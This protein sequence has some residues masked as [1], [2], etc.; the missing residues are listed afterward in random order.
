MSIALPA[1]DV[2]DDGPLAHGSRGSARAAALE[3]VALQSDDL[4]DL[5]ASSSGTG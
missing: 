3:Q 1:A 4:C 5:Q 2:R